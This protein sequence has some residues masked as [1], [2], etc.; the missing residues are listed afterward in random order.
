MPEVDEY[1]RLKEM[2]ALLTQA[3]KE[4]E[5]MELE[6]NRLRRREN[7]K[8]ER[9]VQLTQLE[10]ESKDVV[11]KIAEIDRLLKQH[12]SGEAIE[13]LDE[14]G[15]TLL[16]RQQEI[17]TL[18]EE[19]KTF[20]SGFE[21]TL[22]EIKAEIDEAIVRHKN[23]RD[24]ALMRAKLLEADLSPDTLRAYRKIAAAKPSH[25]T[26][27]RIESGHCLFCR[28]AVSRPVESEV[29]AQLLLKACSSCG[30][31]FLPHKAVYG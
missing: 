6:I 22:L 17:E 28:S 9:H 15:L 30:R 24:Q 12:L 18:I 27:S 1:L 19:S 8:A 2:D 31:L 11:H 20:L 10:R 25:S 16:I 13:K 3:N 5:A 21:K 26:F 14:D 7:E 4:S 23:L 29:E